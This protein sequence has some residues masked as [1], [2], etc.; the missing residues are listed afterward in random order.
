MGLI[1][2]HYLPYWLTSIQKKIK[3]CWVLQWVAMVFSFDTFSCEYW[4]LNLCL[5][6]I[7]SKYH[8]PYVPFHNIF[9]PLEPY[10]HLNA[11][12]LYIW[13]KHVS[14][15]N[16]LCMELGFMG[17]SNL[18]LGWIFTFICLRD[19]ILSQGLFIFERICMVQFQ[20]H[21][22]SFPKGIEIVLDD[23]P[24]FCIFTRWRICFRCLP[25]FWH[26]VEFSWRELFGLINGHGFNGK[27]L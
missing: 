1:C 25:L 4:V 16:T 12:T 3:S 9:S 26:Y 11:M 27:W 22:L 13:R 18:C 5:V 14:Y 19:T 17:F 20:N 23:K 15:G 8:S 24:C 7:H 10:R 2:S 21:A 6:S